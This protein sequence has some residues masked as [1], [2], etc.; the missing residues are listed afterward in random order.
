[1][2]KIRVAIVDDHWVVRAGLRA[3]LEADP[4]FEIVGEASGGREGLGLLREQSPDVALVDIKLPDM[5]GAEVCQRATAEGIPTA[6]VILTAFVNWKLV[7]SCLRAGAKGYVL[8]ETRQ[9]N[10]RE[11]L[12]SV[13]HGEIVLS[14][15]VASLV[16]KYVQAQKQ[17]DNELTLSV[18]EMEVLR[19]MSQGMSN[20]EIGKHLFLSEGRVKDYVS[21]ILH[22][23]GAKNRVEVILIAVRSGFL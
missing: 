3:I 15:K 19:L 11:A 2:K 22:K 16:A 21:S 10:L 7:Q 9:L 5:S 4:T 8:K 17:T 1:M 13:A 14:P 12:I 23:L 18:R 20:K 6:I